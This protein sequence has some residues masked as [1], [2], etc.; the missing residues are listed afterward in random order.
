M[1]DVVAVA[2]V[3]VVVINKSEVRNYT[4]DLHTLTSATTDPWRMCRLGFQLQIS[5]NRKISNW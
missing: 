5:E 1:V 2:V 3:D 4:N